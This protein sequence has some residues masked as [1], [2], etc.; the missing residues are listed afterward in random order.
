M[1]SK[2]VEELIKAKGGPAKM[3]AGVTA[4]LVSVVIIPIGLEITSLGIDYFFKKRSK[5]WAEKETARRTESAQVP[6][7]N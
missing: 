4:L 2:V 6:N 7:R 5:S 1:A 3:N